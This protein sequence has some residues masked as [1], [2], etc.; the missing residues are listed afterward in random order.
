MIST[1]AASS[2]R[3][4]IT[5]KK[6][7]K[8]WREAGASKNE[9][10]WKEGKERRNEKIRMTKVETNQTKDGRKNHK[11]T[12]KTQKNQEEITNDGVTNMKN[13]DTLHVDTPLRYKLKSLK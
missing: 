13:V 3:R 10:G 11:K 8:K 6:Y 5:R 2:K 7:T 12:S 9:K 1:N 4:P